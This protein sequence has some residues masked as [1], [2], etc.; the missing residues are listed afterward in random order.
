MYIVF[1]I[2]CEQWGRYT[3]DSSTGEQHL[4][5]LKEYKDTN[6]L[7][8]VAKTSADASDWNVMLGPMTNWSTSGL[9]IKANL[10]GYALR[11]PWY[12]SGILAS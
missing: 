5:F 12:V 10:K 2:F 11:G 9:L 1:I 8:L 3:L 6:Y 7:V 4:T